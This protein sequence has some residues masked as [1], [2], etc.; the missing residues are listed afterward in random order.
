MPLLSRPMSAAVMLYPG[1]YLVH[2]IDERYYGIGT[3]DF[4]TQYF[5]IYFT[6][7]AWWAVNVPSLMMLTA[8]ATLV[9]RQVWPRWLAVAL[10]THLAL[11]G[12]MRVPTS[13]WTL[14]IAP[15]LISGLLLCLPLSVITLLWGWS[16]LPRTQF[17]NGI[18]VGIASFQHLWHFLLL[19]VLPGGPAAQQGAAAGTAGR[20]VYEGGTVW[21]R[22][23]GS[24]ALLVAAR[25]AA[26]RPVRCAARG[27]DR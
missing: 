22:V 9:A 15:G 18:L 11:H 5:G 26:E 13:A 4:A 21:Q 23:S 6:N 8:T 12:L 10:A 24:L 7:E 25:G 16:A 20:A 19:P 14:T 3:A 2:L 17:R 27:I 1:V